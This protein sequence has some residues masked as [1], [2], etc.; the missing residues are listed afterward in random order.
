MNRQDYIN[1]IYSNKGS[2]HIIRIAFEEYKKI[3]YDFNTFNMQLR[4]Y[5]MENGIN[6]QQIIELIEEFYDKK[7]NITYLIN[8]DN[9]IINLF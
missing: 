4:M 9:Q 8:K 7:F 5:C 2:P 1:Y 3:N 6:Q